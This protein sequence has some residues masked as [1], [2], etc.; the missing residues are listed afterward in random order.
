MD[1]GRHGGIQALQRSRYN[2]LGPYNDDAT[3][4]TAISTRHVRLDH[5]HY[6]EFKVPSLRNL[7]HTAPYMHDGSLT[8]LRDVLQHYSE[9]D[10][11]RLHADGEAILVPLRLTAQQTDDLLAFLD[12]LN[13]PGGAPR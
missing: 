11:N 9:L 2:L 10:E 7:A 13:A 8:T 6:G 4:A 3:R 5:R 1:P 12:S